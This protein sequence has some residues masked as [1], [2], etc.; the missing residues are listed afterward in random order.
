LRIA[1]R[2]SGA[3]KASGSAADVPNV[4][5]FAAA[6]PQTVTVATTFDLEF[7]ASAGKTWTAEL[8]QNNGAFWS[9]LEFPS[10]TAGFVV[11]STVNSAQQ[12]VG[13]VYRTTNSGKSWSAL[14]LP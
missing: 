5:D 8:P 13:T 14:S 2:L 4:A 1:G 12:E 10:A 11:C 9:G 3:F 7:S 6:S